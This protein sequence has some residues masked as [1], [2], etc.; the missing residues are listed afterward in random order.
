MSENLSV[1]YYQKK[2]KKKKK[3]KERLQNKSS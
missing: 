3:K 2:K 1:K